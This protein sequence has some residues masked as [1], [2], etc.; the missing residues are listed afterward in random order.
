M[1]TFPLDFPGWLSALYWPFRNIYTRE[2]HVLLDD[3]QCK[4]LIGPR[5]GDDAPTAHHN[6]NL[7]PDYVLFI[8]STK[9]D[10]DSMLPL[11]SLPY[12]YLCEQHD[13]ITIGL[14]ATRELTTTTMTILLLT[15]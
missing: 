10:F 2:E 13:T 14:H 12:L 3:D 8:I 7:Q 9:E 4:Q 15:L 6:Y 11:C 1:F 5:Y